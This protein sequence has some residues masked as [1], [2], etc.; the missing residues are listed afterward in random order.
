MCVTA[1]SLFL[2]VAPIRIRVHSPTPRSVP[3]ASSSTDEMT[4]SE[5][6]PLCLR[7]HSPTR[8][9]NVISNFHERFDRSLESL[10]EI[11]MDSC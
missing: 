10:D 6:P 4:F 7:L 5:I 1:L 2:T 8:V 11:L 9:S 3:V